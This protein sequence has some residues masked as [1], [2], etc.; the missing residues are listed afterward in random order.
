MLD[1]WKIKYK[2]SIQNIF[3]FEETSRLSTACTPKDSK[4]GK[5]YGGFARIA[6]LVRQAKS[7]TQTIFLNAGDTYQGTAWY[8]VYK[9]RAVAV[10]MTLLEPDVIVSINYQIVQED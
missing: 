7:E 8:N 9:W 6:T 3:R 1:Q 5:C 2:Y 4:E 10:F